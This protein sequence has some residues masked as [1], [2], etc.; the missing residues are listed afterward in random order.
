MLSL[1][2]LPIG[3]N[4]TELGANGMRARICIT[5]IYNQ[6]IRKYML[7]FSYYLFDLFI[8]FQRWNITMAGSIH[9]SA[10]KL[11]VHLNHDRWLYLIHDGIL[12]L[13]IFS[14]WFFE[15]FRLLF[16][17]IFRSEIIEFFISEITNFY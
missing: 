8:E 13:G 16:F 10:C 11:M 6:C 15:F 17:E 1:K 4:G 7:W 14:L 2:L 3:G 12:F 5:N 9:K